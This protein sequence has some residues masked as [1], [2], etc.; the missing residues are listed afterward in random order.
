[1]AQ[2]T[3]GFYTLIADDDLKRMLGALLVLDELG[4]PEEFRV[5]FPVKPTLIQ[6]QLYGES[7]FPHVGVELCGLPLYQALKAKPQLMVVSHLEFLLL[8]DMVASPLVFLEPAGST[9]VVKGTSSNSRSAQKQIESPSGRF[10]PVRVAYPE[11]YSPERCSQ[12]AALVADFFR[13]ID[14][15]EPFD[16]IDVAVQMLQEQDEKFR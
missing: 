10:E 15:L 3:V 6:R 11:T 4:K 8:G 12:A 2:K 5:T 13:A 1:M 14:L 9:L 7:L 16:R